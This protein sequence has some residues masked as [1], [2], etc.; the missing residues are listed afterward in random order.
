MLHVTETAVEFSGVT[1]RFPGVVAL[2]N[3][4]FSIAAGSCH[5]LCGE[6]GAG[7]STL[8]RM[9]AGIAPQDEGEIVLFGQRRR[10]SSPRQAL[11]AGVAIVHQELAFC[12]NLS[13]MENLCLQNL[14]ARNTFVS[15][16]AMRE[17][18]DT[19]LGALEV[20]IDVTRPMESLSIAEQQ[21][22]HIAAAVAGNAR[23]VIFDEPTS[24]LG[25]VESE[26]LFSLIAR[27][28]ERGVTLVYVT[29]RLNEVFKL[30]DAVTV[31]RDGAH[32]STQPISEVDE[33][34]L[35]Q[36]MIGRKLE[37]YFPSHATA[38]R[39]A[40]V[41]RVESLSA[42][43]GFADISFDLHE[44]E[45]V[46]LAGQKGA[47]RSEIAQALFGLTK[48]TSGSIAIRG[49]QTEIRSPRHAIQLGIG[50]VPEDR[51][52]Q[53]LVLSLLARENLTLPIVDLFSRMWII[54]RRAET[55][56]TS[57][58]FNRLHI[59]ARYSEFATDAL[60]GGNQQKIVFAKSIAT[61][62]RILILDEPTRGVDVGAKAELHA[63]IDGLA[64][65][66]VAIILISSE[67]PEL[68]NLSSRILVLRAGQLVGEVS[69]AQASQG[70]LL[71]LMTGTKVA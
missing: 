40:P 17:R 65:D 27:L 63:W 9:L 41:M 42:A 46:G 12:G 53:G 5:A 48:P 19:L 24:S 59:P 6:N 62:S 20:R 54:N 1:K 8:G 3:V 7:K 68:I 18:A 56:L 45:V 44:G 22:V 57:G 38:T 55:E 66:G 64:S 29:H 39:G 58:L 43:R 28:K 33:A 23:V 4:S 16:S 51:K 60:S 15:R 47:G 37:Q 30:C 32:V 34:T 31:L 71:R 61:R 70:H 10:F 36:L 67:L 11:D 69:R 26:R 21:L 52:V 25:G 14:P 2:R 35:V 49:K 13:V 50:Y